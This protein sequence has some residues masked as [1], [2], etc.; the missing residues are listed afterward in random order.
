MAKKKQAAEESPEQDG[1]L[2]KVAKTIGEAAGKIATAVGV[3]KPAKPK[4]PKLGKKNKA[5]LPRR[6]K[7]AAKKS[8]RQL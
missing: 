5:R 1:A 7:K 2:A 3:A 6:Q 4:A 8:A